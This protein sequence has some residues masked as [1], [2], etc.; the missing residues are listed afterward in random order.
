[1]SEGSHGNANGIGLADLVTDK[2]VSKVDL[3][4]TYLNV[5][6]TGFV[7]RCFIPL[8][9]P[10][11]KETIEMAI[12]SLGR[13]AAKDLRLMII[14]TTLHLEKVYVSE[15]LVAGAENAGPAWKWQT[16]R[17]RSNSM[18]AAAWSTG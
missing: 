12:A 17:W 9:F 14:P 4:S 8:H 13:I 7:Q 15:A 18:P 3:K 1:M 16:S 10:S 11:E 5:M 6:T 2:L